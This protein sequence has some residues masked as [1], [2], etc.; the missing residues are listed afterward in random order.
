VLAVGY[1][2]LEA[3]VQEERDNDDATRPLPHPR[4]RVG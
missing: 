1:R 3:W 2:L 4:E